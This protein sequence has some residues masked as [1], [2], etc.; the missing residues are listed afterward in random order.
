MIAEWGRE[1]RQLREQAFL[2]RSRFVV[3]LEHLQQITKVLVNPPLGIATNLTP[4][5]PPPSPSRPPPKPPPLPPLLPPPLPL[6][7]MQRLKPSSLLLLMMMIAMIATVLRS[8][9][10][11][12][13]SVA[14]DMATLIVCTPRRTSPR[15]KIE[16]RA[17][18]L[19]AYVL[20]LRVISPAPPS[21]SLRSHRVCLKRD[22]Q[23]HSFHDLRFALHLQMKNGGAG[24]LQRK[25]ARSLCCRC[26]TCRR[27]EALL[28]RRNISHLPHTIVRD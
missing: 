3:L 28:I 6:P 22:D 21:S 13:I 10:S 20:L 11:S 18:K 2:E 7:P 24:F 12:L 9:S 16:H 27:M 23:V 19:L 15:S 8:S 25:Y 14:P 4:R 5:P 1:V 26:C 17:Q